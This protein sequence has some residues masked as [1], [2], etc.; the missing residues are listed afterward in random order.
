MQLL[1]LIWGMVAMV[2]FTVAFIPCLGSL[3]W[4]NI[5]FAIVGAI[6]SFVAMNGAPPGRRG[7]AMVGLILNLIAVVIGFL[8]LKVG[9]F[10]F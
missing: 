9:F 1:S 4:L 2:G 6:I 3:N 5:P 10:I 8:R 7:T